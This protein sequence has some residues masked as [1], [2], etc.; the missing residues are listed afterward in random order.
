MLAHLKKYLAA[1]RPI[2][3]ERPSTTHIPT[4]VVEEE[5][6]QSGGELTLKGSD[7][8]Q[9]YKYKYKYKYNYKY[10]YK[11]KYKYRYKYKYKEQSGGEPSRLTLKGS[12][13][14]HP[15]QTSVLV[16]GLCPPK[17]CSIKKGIKKNLEKLWSFTKPTGGSP[18]VDK[19]TNLL[20]ENVF[21]P[22]EYAESF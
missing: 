22:S 8:I 9:A 20:F 11:Y 7:P 17:S 12:D 6:E 2:S 13:S 10:K 15:I 18:R 5:T 21:F 4:G 19:K 16:F 3:P 14:W 1:Q